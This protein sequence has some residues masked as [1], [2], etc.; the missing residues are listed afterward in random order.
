M[1]MSGI[2]AQLYMPWTLEMSMIVCTP[3][4]GL[5]AKTHGCPPPPRETNLVMLLWRA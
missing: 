5:Q 4:C 1:L 3:D 2:L